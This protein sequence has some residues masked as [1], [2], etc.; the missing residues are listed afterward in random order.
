M[1]ENEAQNPGAV[2]KRQLADG[3]E[4]APVEHPARRPRRHQAH[5]GLEF[6]GRLDRAGIVARVPAERLLQHA[7]LVDFRNRRGQPPIGL[8]RALRRLCGRGPVPV[9]ERMQAARRIGDVEPLAGGEFEKRLAVVDAVRARI[10]A[11]A[12]RRELAGVE[13]R[14][15]QNGVQGAVGD[16]VIMKKSRRVAVETLPLVV[17]DARFE[18]DLVGVLA[19]IGFQI[20]GETTHDL[21]PFRPIARR[22]PASPHPLFGRLSVGRRQVPGRVVERQGDV[23][24]FVAGVEIGS[25]PRLDQ[26]GTEMKLAVIAFHRIVER[27]SSLST[28][29]VSELAQPVFVVTAH[30]AIDDEAVRKRN[31]L[32]EPRLLSIGKCEVVAKNVR[33]QFH[34]SASKEE[35]L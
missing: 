32:L 31:F 13:A 2:E 16:F 19:Q 26:I 28:V 1:I 34:E 24:R 6:E 5:Q 30:Y 11:D 23:G 18:A 10:L 7:E 35:T 4:P 21:A 8:D 3:N 14:A 12:R 17:F 33:R 9:E 29:P 27:A 20:R 15:R 22:R 25:Q